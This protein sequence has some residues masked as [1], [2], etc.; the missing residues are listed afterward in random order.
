MDK[1]VLKDMVTVQAKL[2]FD[3]EEDKKAV[4]DLMRKMV[5][6]YEVCI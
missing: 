1:E 6:L 2:V 3:R 4:L 5:L